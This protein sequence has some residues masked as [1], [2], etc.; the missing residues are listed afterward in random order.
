M[1]FHLSNIP[2]S[3]HQHE[4]QRQVSLKLTCKLKG[5]QLHKFWDPRRQTFPLAAQLAVYRSSVTKIPG[6]HPPL[7]SRVDMR[8]NLLLENS[9][10]KFPGGREQ[11]NTELVTLTRRRDT[12][13][14]YPSFLLPSSPGLVAR[15]S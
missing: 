4:N 9:G 14:K 13:G 1:Q 3:L 8:L 11:C 12:A 5:Q 15:R 2:C 10:T 6:F 7:R